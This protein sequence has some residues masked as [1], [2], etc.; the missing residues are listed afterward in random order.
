VLLGEYTQRLDAKNRLTLPAKLRAAFAEGVVVTKGF[1]SCLFV[2]PRGSWNS[3]VESRLERLD[4][5][6]RESRVLS[7]WFYGGANE[8][9][10]DG[11]GRVM[12]SQ[13]LLQHAGLGKNIIVAGAR[14]YL[15][16]WDSEAWARQQAE[17][18]GSVEDVAERLSQ[19]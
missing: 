5:F 13:A 8:C 10:L 11:Q 7:R 1:D 18:E 12:L 9:E 4:P 16:V 17:S 15:E 3:F 19:Q 6:N 14:D 2:F